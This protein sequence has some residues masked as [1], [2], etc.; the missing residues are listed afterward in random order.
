MIATCGKCG[1][2]GEVSGNI[3]NGW[4]FTMFYT[5]ERAESGYKKVSSVALC[6]L[7]GAVKPKKVWRANKRYMEINAYSED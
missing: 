3:S 6:P 7:C 5:G 2:K 4:T 1:A